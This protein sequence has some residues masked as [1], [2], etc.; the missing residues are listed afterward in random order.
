M[1]QL[2]YIDYLIDVDDA[3]LAER[4]SDALFTGNGDRYNM[5]ADVWYCAVVIEASPNLRDRTIA[6]LAR[7]TVHPL[8][9]DTA[10]AEWREEKEGVTP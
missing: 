1:R 3:G 4:M 5:E 7:I 10:S 9:T 6:W 2:T 8:D